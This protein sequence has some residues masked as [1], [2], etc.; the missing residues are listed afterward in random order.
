MKIL[1]SLFDFTGNWSRC[2]RENGW[3]VLQLDI[4]HG[5]D[6][7]DFNAPKFWSE[8][9][10]LPMSQFPHKIGILAAIPCNDYALSGAKH[11]SAKDAD[12]RTE[13]SQKLVNTTKAIIDFFEL[14]GFL[15]FWQLKTRPA[16]YIL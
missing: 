10:H 11:F 9:Q 1:I 15:D 14:T 16:G 3:R 5:F 8:I 4:K 13:A 12:G 6:I 2:Y 7:M